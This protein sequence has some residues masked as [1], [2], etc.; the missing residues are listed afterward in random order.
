[1]AAKRRQVASDTRRFHPARMHALHTDV[2]VFQPAA[3]ARRPARLASFGASSGCTAMNRPADPLERGASVDEL[4]DRAATAANG[5][6]PE[7]GS[8]YRPS[9]V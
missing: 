8:P 6:S 2:A 7:A 1:M 4:L 3:P 5:M 9:G